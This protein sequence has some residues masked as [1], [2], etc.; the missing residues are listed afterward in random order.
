MTVSGDP[1]RFDDDGPVRV[2]T[3]NRPDRRNAVDRP[4]VPLVS[5]LER[6]VTERAPDQR[7]GN[8]RCSRGWKRLLSVAFP[9]M[10]V[11][12]RP[13]VRPRTL[14][15]SSALVVAS[16]VTG[17]AAAAQRGAQVAQ[18]P[19]VPAVAAPPVVDSPYG[20]VA[21]WGTVTGT[22]GRVYI[23][24]AKGRALQFHGFNV[25]T[26]NPDS[27]TDALLDQAAERGMDH[28]RLSIYWQLIEPTQGNYDA[29]Y[30]ASIVSAINRSAAHGI[31]VIL[32]M[33]QDVYGEAFDS[34]GAPT[35]ATRT[36]G[37]PFTPQAT[38]LLNYLQPAV[39]RAF[40]H[41]YDDADLRQAQ[42]DVWLKVVSQVQGLP[43]LLGYDLMNEPFGEMLPGE[44]LFQAAE[45][46]ERDQ[47][48]P[49]YQRLT[50]AIANVDPAHWV[51]FEPPN[52]AS[53]GVT[54]SLGRVTGP[55]VAIYPHMYDTS[56]ESSTYDPNS[57]S[58]TY[59]P[60]FFSDWANAITGY[61]QKYPMPM[62]VGEWGIAKPEAHSMDQF[63]RDSLATLD[64]VTS[65]WSMF[66]FCDGS[67]YC[68]IDAD[69]NDRLNIGQIFEPYARA[70]AGAPTSSTYDFSTRQLEVTFR[71]NAA[72]GSTDIFL[73]ASRSYPDGWKVLTSDAAGTWTESFDSATGV[74]SVTTAKDGGD[75]AICVVPKDSVIDS[76][77]VDAAVTF[78]PSAPTARPATPV[79]AQPTFTG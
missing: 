67:G 32:D 59:D 31:R 58:Y 10:R 46:V 13:F 43:G 38:W 76:C 42:I 45:R 47:L 22:D 54:T 78:G 8:P 5:S 33:H 66:N 18:A 73:P 4:T 11:H 37:L 63:V 44:S 77:P 48:T 57:D 25:K 40:T 3:I 34:T 16:T 71:D 64:K 9:L 51:F 7:R 41:L 35:W 29:A 21:D 1:V 28:L 69:G 2:I 14:L 65:G 79:A 70:I 30:L 50:D 15:L 26:D 17:T 36:D 60:K 49:M 55:K 39:Q 56:L 6:D 72:S 20:D 23:A 19:A 52:L 24:D 53:L 12:R 75:H 68:P 27:V 61:V 74:L 62:L